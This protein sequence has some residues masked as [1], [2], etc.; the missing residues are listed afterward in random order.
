MTTT[1]IEPANVTVLLRSR[2]S[3]EASVRDI[4]NKQIERESLI[5]T[6]DAAIALVANAHNPAIDKLTA[7]IDESFTLLE[8]WAEQN[9]LT[10]FK[11]AKSIVISGHRL[12]FRLGT[13]KVEGRGKLTLKAILARLVKAG[14]ELKDL[15]VRE[16][17]E[18]NKDAILAVN[19]TAEGRDP[20]LTGLDQDSREQMQKDAAA[21]L[22]N[23][24]VVVTQTEAFYFEPDREGQPDIRMAGEAKEAA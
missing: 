8:D 14:G 6:R 3:A 15:F 16:K 19:R 20:S 24:G 2:E 7:E 23:I 22:R 10:E 5:A 21:T 18:L 9:R 11:D 12:G 13:P 1:T 17:P 4:I